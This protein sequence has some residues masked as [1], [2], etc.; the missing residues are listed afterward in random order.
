ME[1]HPV[2]AATSRKSIEMSPASH[3]VSKLQASYEIPDS[4]VPQLTQ[5]RQPGST[6]VL[7]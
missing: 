2:I 4:D 3:W 5:C 1:Y 7:H 6:S